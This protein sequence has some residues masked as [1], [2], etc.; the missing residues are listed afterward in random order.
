MNFG[1]RRTAFATHR[2]NERPPAASQHSIP[3]LAETA[4]SNLYMVGW[5]YLSPIWDTGVKYSAQQAGTGPRHVETGQRDAAIGVRATGVL[6]EQRRCR[7]SNGERHVHHNISAANPGT[8]ACSVGPVAGHGEHCRLG[9]AAQRSNRLAHVTH[10]ST[11]K[12]YRGKMPASGPTPIGNHRRP[13]AP[14]GQSA[15]SRCPTVLPPIP[16]FPR[17]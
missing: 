11:V 12:S 3:D 7:A 14:P 1:G 13:P 10:K 17:P 6:N 16:P 8:P 4:I 2:P 9:Q 15:S 5:D